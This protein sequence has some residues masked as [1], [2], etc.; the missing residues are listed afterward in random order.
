MFMV[1]C[2]VWFVVLGDESYLETLSSFKKTST[3][4]VNNEVTLHYGHSD[5]HMITFSEKVN[6]CI[7]ANEKYFKKA[8]K[9]KDFSN[10]VM[11]CYKKF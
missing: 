1:F 7:T 5:N 11:N 6:F 2:G 8:F 9:N 10:S 3:T 4:V